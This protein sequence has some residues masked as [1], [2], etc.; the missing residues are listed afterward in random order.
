MRARARWKSMRSGPSGID[1]QAP[2]VERV[3]R[4]VLRGRVDQAVEIR[5]AFVRLEPIELMTQ[6]HRAHECAVGLSV[7]KRR[8]RRLEPDVDG[9]EAGRGKTVA[10]LVDAGEE[11]RV[12]PA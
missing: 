2:V 5:L 10:G 9:D 8:R 1:V 7:G 3:W 11:P 6:A 4:I 12:T